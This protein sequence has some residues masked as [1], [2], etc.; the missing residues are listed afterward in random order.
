[1]SVFWIPF[2]QIHCLTN[3]PQ[4]ST[5][6][7]NII[8][9]NQLSCVPNQTNYSLNLPL[10]VANDTVHNPY[11]CGD[12]S[13]SAL[14]TLLAD[15]ALQS[16]WYLANQC[17]GSDSLSADSLNYVWS[18]GDSLNSTST[19]AY[20]SF[21]Y[22]SPGNYVICVTITDPTNGCTSTYC[23]SSTY[24]SKST[25]NQMIQVNVVPSDSPLL[26]GLPHHLQGREEIQLYPN[27]THNAITISSTD[28][29]E[30][31]LLIDLLGN[32]VLKLNNTSHKSTLKAD[33]EGLPAGIYI[34]K[35]NG[36]L[37][38]KVVKE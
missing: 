18:W 3:L 17:L 35:V 29:I 24:I 4:V 25:A 32:E 6:S 8:F 15:S 1:M 20:P 30:Q 7:Q 13:C 34:C 5:V 2:N 14:Y 26:T 33:V 38:G 22:S 28:V 9:G 19:G 12:N 31:V 16:V 36:K 23:D 21:T 27:P 11:H 10:C 37:V